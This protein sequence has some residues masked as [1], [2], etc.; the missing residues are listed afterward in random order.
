MSTTF[1]PVN[2]TATAVWSGADSSEHPAAVPDEVLLVPFTRS[3][4]PRIVGA[5][6]LDNGESHRKRGEECGLPTAVS[7]RMRRSDPLRAKD[8]VH[9]NTGSSQRAGA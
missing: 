5:P 2:P 7:R 9:Q 1:A 3:V 6:S 4:R 8:P